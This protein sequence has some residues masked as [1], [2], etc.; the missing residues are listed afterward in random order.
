MEGMRWT[1]GSRSKNVEDRRAQGG[2]GGGM[3]LGGGGVSLLMLLFRRFGF[4][5][6][7]VGGIALYLLSRGGLSGSAGL[8]SSQEGASDAAE[9]PL[10]EFV[11]FVLDDAQNTWAGIFAAQNAQYTPAKLVLFRGSTRSGC[12]FGQAEM[13]PFYCP[14]DQRVYIDLGFYSE[15]KQRFGAPGDFAQA[16]V[17]THEIGHHV[18]HLLGAFEKHPSREGAGESSVRM[19]LQADCYAGIWGHSTQQRNVLEQGDLE[20]ALK[21]A[22]AIGDDALQ[23]QGGGEVAPDSFTHGTSEQRVR[24][25]RRGFESG[26][27]EAC[28]TFAAA[29]L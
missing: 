24:W 21:A 28:D 23:R 26:K 2:S 18:Q 1:S 4:P 16:Y 5:G 3:S 10:V 25:F 7:V 19:E 8:S 20:E 17:I 11:S 29:R 6:L 15:L 13:G 22:T 27:L 14:N 9:E 12:G